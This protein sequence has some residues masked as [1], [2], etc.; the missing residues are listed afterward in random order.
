MNQRVLLIEW[1]LQ[2]KTVHCYNEIWSFD[3]QKKNIYY[4][5]VSEDDGELQPMSDIQLSQDG[6]APADDLPMTSATLQVLSCQVVV[7]VN[8]QDLPNGGVDSCWRQFLSIA[9]LV[10]T[11]MYQ[12]GSPPPPWHPHEY[13]TGHV[14]RRLRWLAEVELWLGRVVPE[15]G[16]PCH[17]DFCLPLCWHLEELTWNPLVISFGQ[18]LLP[19]FCQ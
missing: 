19:S 18:A 8:V 17:V 12:P 16:D 2:F 9:L 7:T 3:K 14:A 15:I 5:L 4:S 6:L 1:K 11:Y 13:A 10:W